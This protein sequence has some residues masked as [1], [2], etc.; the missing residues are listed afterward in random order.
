MIFK[1]QISLFLAVLLLVSNVGFAFDVHYCGDTIASVS[2]DAGLSS[3]KSEK[4]CCETISSKKEG[5]CKDKV[6]NFQKKSSN[7]I[8]KAFIFE[9]NSP[10][11]APELYS[12]VFSKNPTFENKKTTSYYCDAN[13]PPLFKLYNQYIFYA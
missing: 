2:F 12:I 5:C 13:A 1:R 6:F 8:L 7:A 10:F 9:I 11:F 3:L 4:G